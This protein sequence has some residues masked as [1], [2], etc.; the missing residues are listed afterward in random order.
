MR[1]KLTVS[2]FV[3]FLSFLQPMVGLAQD[4]SLPIIDG[5]ITEGEYRRQIQE[6]T[7]NISIY[8]YNDEEYLYT[9]LVSPGLGWIAIAFERNGTFHR[10]ADIIFAYVKNGQLSIYDQYGVGSEIHKSDEDL[11]GTY[12][13]LES[14]GTESGGM[15]TVEFRIPLNSGDP[16]DKVL[17]PN[18]NY[19]VLVA[20]QATADD[21][22]TL[23]TRAGYATIDIVPEF[24]STLVVA[25]FFFASLV[26]V[27]LHKWRLSCSASTKEHAKPSSSSVLI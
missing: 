5:V 1:R 2:V 13:I 15:T 3:F 14:A 23:H 8:L 6:S 25:L 26:A 12:D 17:V 24:T 20:Y 22:I 21:L 11:G 27:A 18:M 16:F 9:G 7:T 19:A 4:I 10:G